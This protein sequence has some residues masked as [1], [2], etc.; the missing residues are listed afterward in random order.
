MNTKSISRIGK[1]DYDRL[2]ALWD[3]AGLPYKAGGRD[4]AEAFEQQLESGRLIALG[5]ENGAGELIGSVLATH[6]GRRGWIN[7]LAV[8]R[9]YRRQGIATALI[10]AAEDALREQGI[11][12]FAALVEPGNEGS[13][14]VFEEAG[15]TDWPGIHYLSKRDRPDV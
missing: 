7:R 8:R 6:D 4:S 10:H 3:A 13:V 2:L 9:D 14:A 11:E 5:V 12:I 1:T 15:Y